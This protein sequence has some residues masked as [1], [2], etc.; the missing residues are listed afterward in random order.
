MIPPRRRAKTTGYTPGLPDFASFVVVYEAW[1]SRHAHVVQESCDAAALKE[2]CTMMKPH[3]LLGVVVCAWLSWTGTVHADAVT[4]WNVIGVQ[5][6]AMAAPPRPGP[7]RF[8]DLAIVQA[9][10]YDA[11][12]AIDRRFQPYHTTIPGVT[13]SPAAAAASAAHDILVNI[14]PS[15][16]T[17]L[18]TTY[19]EY[20]A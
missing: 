19:H 10:V 16:A 8:L 9:A 5:A 2:G 6:L 18:D 20:L 11:V 4:D 7:V 1:F 15:Q 12:Q 13:G 17:S 3:R 14:V